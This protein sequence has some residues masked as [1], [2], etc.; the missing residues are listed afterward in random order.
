MTIS[1]PVTSSAGEIWLRPTPGKQVLVGGT[2][3]A[4]I[5][6]LDT[7][8]LGNLSYG[9]GTLI[10][11]SAAAGDMIAFIDADCRAQLDDAVAFAEESPVP[12]ADEL[13][14]HVLVE[15]EA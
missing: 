9:S 6:G 10:I 7:T 15:A 5:L 12:E 2:D 8:D 11:G 4:N 13:Y 1:N 3:A 14:R